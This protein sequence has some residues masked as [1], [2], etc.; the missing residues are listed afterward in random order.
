MEIMNKQSTYIVISILIFSL[1]VNLTDAV[2]HPDYFVKIPIKIL[3]FFI[4]FIIFFAANKA[5]FSEFKKIFI[6]R[7]GGLFRSLLLGAAIY[8]VIVLG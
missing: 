1:L 6:F 4:F 2:V 5:D 8:A 3:F 7:R